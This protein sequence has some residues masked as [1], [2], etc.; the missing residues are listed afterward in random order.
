M[1]S[2]P[3]STPHRVLAA[4]PEHPLTASDVLVLQASSPVDFART[5]L[6]VTLSSTD[7]PE[8]SLD[9]VG[10]MVTLVDAWDDPTTDRS[11]VGFHF[12]TPSQT[13][14]G[15]SYE[16]DSGWSLLTKEP[17]H[18]IASPRLIADRLLNW[19]DTFYDRP[20]D[21][22]WFLNCVAKYVI[23]QL[24]DR[25]LRGQESEVASL[26]TP[27]GLFGEKVVETTAIPVIEIEHTDKIIAFLMQL[28]APGRADK[29]LEVGY[30]IDGE[31]NW[32]QVWG[33]VCYGLDGTSLGL[34]DRPVATLHRS[35]LRDF[36]DETELL[37]PPPSAPVQID[38]YREMIRGAPVPASA[39]TGCTTWFPTITAATPLV[40]LNTG[41][42]PLENTVAAYLAGDGTGVYLGLN[43]D[44]EV[45]EELIMV[46]LPTTEAETRQVRAS[47]DGWAETHYGA[48]RSSSRGPLVQL[49]RWDTDV[50]HLFVFA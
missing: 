2:G 31:K 36:D 48:L 4:L 38:V 20:T 15:V 45:W 14:V 33:D 12:L 18:D 30:R 35:V 43:L 26:L 42:E 16:P 5:A 3:Y 44:E 7:L 41:G 19:A 24:P 46:D 50:S 34:R 25:P 28:T 9:S 49:E 21:Q 27:G 10:G 47:L 8:T 6:G 1:G 39:W 13:W 22:V 11:I 23:Q 32:R 37:V 40:G 17:A 29:V